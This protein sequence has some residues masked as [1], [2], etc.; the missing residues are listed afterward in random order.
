MSVVDKGAGRDDGLL[1]ND[2]DSPA[3][4]KLLFPCSAAQAAVI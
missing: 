1:P 4:S 3:S 2:N